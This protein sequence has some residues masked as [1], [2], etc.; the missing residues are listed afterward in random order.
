[1]DR[2]YLL[3]NSPDRVCAN[4]FD[5]T[6]GQQTLLLPR[7]GESFMRE[8][9]LCTRDW[10]D[11]MEVRF[12]TEHR[13]SGKHWLVTCPSSLFLSN[14]R[15]AYELSLLGAGYG[16]AEL[17]SQTDAVVAYYQSQPDAPDF[18]RNPAGA[19][20]LTVGK[21]HVQA[22]WLRTDLEDQPEHYAEYLNIGTKAL[23]EALVDLCLPQSGTAREYY[24]RSSGYR[25]LLRREMREL[26][27]RFL[28]THRLPAG[29]YDNAAE[30]HRISAGNGCPDICLQVDKQLLENAWAACAKSLVL[31]LE[32]F[33]RRAQETFRTS[34]PFSEWFSIEVVLCS[35]ADCLMPQITDLVRRCWQSPLPYCPKFY[36]NGAQE[37]V[38][39]GAE[40]MAVKLAKAQALEKGLHLFR[41]EDRQGILLLHKLHRHTVRTQFNRL[42]NPGRYFKKAL[43][44][45]AVGDLNAVEILP[46]ATGHFQTA[47]DSFSDDL[48]AAVQDEFL[49]VVETM[50]QYFLGL[51][52]ATHR[53]WSESTEL[54][55]LLEEFTYMNE[56]H[57]WGEVAHYDTPEW[58]QEFAHLFDYY[59]PFVAQLQP[60]DRTS[61]LKALEAERYRLDQ[62]LLI[63]AR[64]LLSR[65]FSIDADRENFVTSAC[66]LIQNDVLFTLRRLIGFP[67]LEELRILRDLG[68]ITPEQ[69]QDLFACRPS[70]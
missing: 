57:L 59:R 43:K 46:A 17:I 14:L 32:V 52:D 7:D 41:R 6:D 34:V 62:Q 54:D 65:Y 45:W 69:L 5:L 44:N 64:S 2:L 15:G 49:P 24:N 9:I 36:S 40:L 60:V 1:M 30:Q 39:R 4:C 63:R 8:E 11:R 42:T 27:H 19:V 16:H 55:L 13:E 48:Y 18:L 67:S 66:S 26:R 50:R 51:L 38:L 35:G 25:R 37:A 12:P 29:T 21:E 31:P 28:L 23:D 61:Q 33:L 56:N 53:G 70:W 20:V 58:Q 68:E 22:E 10:H 47:C 3:A